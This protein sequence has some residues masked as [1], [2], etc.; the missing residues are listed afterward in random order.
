MIFHNQSFYFMWDK[1]K[2]PVLL[3]QCITVFRKEVFCKLEQKENQRCNQTVW[4]ERKE[5]ER[6]RKAKAAGFSW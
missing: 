3:K 2:G 1:R 5:T 6:E 4:K